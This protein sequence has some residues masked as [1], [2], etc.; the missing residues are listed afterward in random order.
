MF[1]WRTRGQFAALYLPRSGCAALPAFPLREPM[2][3][4]RHFVRRE[5]LFLPRKRLRRPSNSWRAITLLGAPCPRRR[6]S[7][8][9]PAR[10]LLSIRNGHAPAEPCAACE[11]GAGFRA[12]RSN[13]ATILRGSGRG[14]G[15]HYS[16]RASARGAKRPR[17]ARRRRSAV[18]RVTQAPAADDGARETAKAVRRERRSSVFVKKCTFFEKKA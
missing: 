6:L 8:L 17:A 2:I 10:L 11:R 13:R 12:D 18:P 7:H 9:L 5:A 1:L 16:E 14:N 4:N 3:Q 15:Q